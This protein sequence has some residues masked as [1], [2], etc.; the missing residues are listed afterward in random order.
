MKRNTYWRNIL[1]IKTIGRGKTYFIGK[2][3]NITLLLIPSLFLLPSCKH[4]S[5]AELR[6]AA[7]SANNDSTLWHSLQGFWRVEAI[8]YDLDTTFFAPEDPNFIEIH[9]DSIRQFYLVNAPKTPVSVP[10][11]GWFDGGWEGLKGV[12]NKKL[13]AIAVSFVELEGVLKW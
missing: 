7:D 3:V 9:G 4:A 5:E 1:I 12:E 6:Q 10:N 11:R 13:T 8:K 2:N